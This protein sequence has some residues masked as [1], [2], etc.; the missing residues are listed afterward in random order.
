MPSIDELERL[1]GLRDRGV[2]NEDEFARSKR[3]LYEARLGSE[4][5]GRWIRRILIAS[6]V[7]AL[8]AVAVWQIG[9]VPLGS[10]STPSSL[11]ADSRKTPTGSGTDATSVEHATSAPSAEEVVSTEQTVDG[12]APRGDRE[13]ATATTDFFELTTSI[14]EGWAGEEV[15]A[16]DFHATPGFRISHEQS[17]ATIY[18][19][20]VQY[21][22][23]P[24]SS[25]T[26]EGS[27]M[28]AAPRDFESWLVQRP[29][30]QVLRD[31][32]LDI[33]ERGL[34]AYR[35]A[36]DSNHTARDE[37]EPIF[38][39]ATAETGL[40]GDAAHWMSWA[41]SPE[42]PNVFWVKDTS[43]ST[44]VFVLEAAPDVLSTITADAREIV[45]ATELALR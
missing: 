14:P 20:T 21:V 25:E 37:L 41:V 29:S 34:S 26:P 27:D 23:D 24:H 8:A 19:M 4:R 11:V 1:E 32:A 15:H 18:V 10:D 13:Q 43:R 31:G 6:P 2:L 33:P 35:V 3:A 22:W 30:I 45:E 16:Q 5:A 40:E 9:G 36:A 7:L 39:A 38:V 17:N 12:R 44:V 42:L 28:L